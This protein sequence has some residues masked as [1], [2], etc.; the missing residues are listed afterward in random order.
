MNKM[1]LIELSDIMMK[2]YYNLV[3]SKYLSISN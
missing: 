1:N 3:I 2:W